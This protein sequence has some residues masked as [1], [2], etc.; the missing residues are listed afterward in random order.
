MSILREKMSMDLQFKNYSPKTQQAY[1]HHVKRYS[2]YFHQL[3]DQL[4]TDESLIVI[5][6]FSDS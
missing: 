2:E 5:R 6:N 1:M 3:P 4:G